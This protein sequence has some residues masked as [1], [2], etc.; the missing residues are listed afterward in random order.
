MFPK[1]RYQYSEKSNDNQ[2]ENNLGAQLASASK[3]TRSESADDECGHQS[4]DLSLD[5]CDI[6]AGNSS[7]TSID[8]D[9]HDHENIDDVI[10]MSTFKDEP[11]PSSSD[12]EPIYDDED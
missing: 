5:D 6:L 12:D 4:M 2:Q 1:E 10:F 7:D 8:E 11:Q 3:I 9:L